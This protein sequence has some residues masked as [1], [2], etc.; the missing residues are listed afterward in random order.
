M[1]TAV[2]MGDWTQL[3]FRHLEPP[4]TELMNA[5]AKQNREQQ[6]IFLYSWPERNRI[7]WIPSNHLPLFKKIK[8]YWTFFSIKMWNTTLSRPKFKYRALMKF[9]WIA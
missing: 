3:A 4:Q 5:Y 1:E 7:S 9:V 6:S 2:T 8:K